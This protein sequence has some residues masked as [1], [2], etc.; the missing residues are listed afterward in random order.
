MSKNNNF[1][2]Q[3]V[4]IFVLLSSL[5][6]LSLDFLFAKSPQAAFN[7][8]RYFTIQSNFFVTFA[9]IF[10]LYYMRKKTNPNRIINIFILC[11]GIWIFITGLAY[12]FLLS[13]TSH[14]TGVFYVANL[15]LHYVTPISMF[16]FFLFF[17]STTKKDRQ[18]PLYSTIYPIIYCLVSLIRGHF[19]GYYPYWF[20]NPNKPYP[21]G[22]G[23]MSAVLLYIVLLTASFIIVGYLLLLIKK[24]IHLLHHNDL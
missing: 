17:I 9:M 8:L 19:S 2:K 12:H 15:L 1:L 7:L 20:L 24:I 16:I 21:N 11:S 10:V 23:S 5:T 22:C 6:G 13:A 14:P 4:T 18:V 3:V